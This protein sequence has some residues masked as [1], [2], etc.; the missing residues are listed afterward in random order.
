MGSSFKASLCREAI[1]TE[2]ARE[3]LTDPTCGAVLL[4]CGVV[5]NLNRSRAVTRIEYHSHE[6]LALR[7][8][9]KIVEG[10]VES[11][12]QKALA[13][14][15]LGMLEVG[16]TSILLGVSLPHRKEGYA[17][18]ERGMNEIKAE[19]A[20]WKHEHYENDPPEWIE[21]S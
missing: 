13:I 19:V 1:D 8:L 7:S 16:E 12:A 9:E 18:L 3:W 21:G 17:L 2:A 10:L 20:V 15:R 14:H 11:G 5:R 6:S 4:F